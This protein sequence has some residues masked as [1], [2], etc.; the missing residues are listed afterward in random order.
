MASGE[1]QRQHA[2]EMLAFVR[3]RLDA[4]APA[5]KTSP[6]TVRE[7]LAFVRMLYRYGFDIFDEE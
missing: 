3:A 2:R 5:E 1:L 4:V 7:S 6:S